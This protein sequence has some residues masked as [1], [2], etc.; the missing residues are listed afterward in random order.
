MP[1]LDF[2]AS[3]LAPRRTPEE[4]ARDQDLGFGAVVGRATRQRLLNRDGSFN[5]AR[6]GLGFLESLA[7]YHLLLTL[8]W[9]GF[10]GIV[11]LLYLGL[12]LLF[13]A[14]FLACGP[15]ALQGA[16]ADM[17]GGRLG[18]AFFFSTQTFATIGYGQV[19]PNGLAQI[20]RATA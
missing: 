9:P 4:L 19:A 1:P 6:V 14:A 2:E 5:V 13:A 18:R 16:G 8:S 10:L 7:P 15:D 11:A 17:L 3:P 20:R 12:N